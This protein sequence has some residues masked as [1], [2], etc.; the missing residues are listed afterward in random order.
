MAGFLL[1]CKGCGKDYALRAVHSVQLVCRHCQ[2]LI[3]KDKPLAFGKTVA[4]PRED[5]S[6]LRIGATGKEEKGSFEVIGRIQHFYHHGYRN[7]WYV[8]YQNG[9]SGW[10][11]DWEGGYSLLTYHQPKSDFGLLSS[12]PGKRVTILGSQFEVRRLTRHRIF[13][14]E[15]ELPE[16][17][18]HKESF[19]AV[20]LGNEQEQLVLA[21][22]YSTKDA[23]IFAGKSAIVKTMKYI[24]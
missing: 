13:Y 21:H 1:R 18:L 20:E 6:V 23:E 22:L 24:T 15:G 3:L 10:L 14:P 16:L 11:G 12:A 7:L 4:A 8:L 17:S 2:Q 9:D 5:M 19:M